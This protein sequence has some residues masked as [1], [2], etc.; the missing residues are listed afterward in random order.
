MNNTKGIILAGGMATRLFPITKTITKQLLPI[1]DKP[2]IYYPLTLLM[3]AK[4]RD[5]AIIVS[6]EQ[7]KNFYSVL[8]DGSQWGI[9][10]TYLLQNKPDGIGQAYIIAEKFLNNNNSLMI[11][12]DNLFYGNKIQLIL[13]NILEKKIPSI[14]GY[15]V[16]DPER[17]GVI[18]FNGNKVT[19]IIE[20]PKRPASN[21]VVT[22]L[23]YLDK[24]ASKYAKTIK[25]SKR[26][27]L[28]I[29][30][31][32]NIY[33]K[34][35]NLH[36]ELFGRGFAWLDTGTADSLLDA[37]N[38]VKTIQARQ[39]SIVG[40]PEEIS[41]LN[42]WISKNKIKNMIKTNNKSEYFNYLNRL[43]D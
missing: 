23:Y 15:K 19:K 43:I 6:P 5:I 41:L 18:S 38:F 21:F 31:I 28:E 30:D 8:K 1:Y 42:K 22:G 14:F 9:K 33:L 35:K 34:N 7:K 37:S 25:K 39:G 16:S 36:T 29:S 32:L 13:K 26:G 17:Y 2:M 3:L 12:G 11:L 20:K 27:E 24:N 10:L 40:S 4:I